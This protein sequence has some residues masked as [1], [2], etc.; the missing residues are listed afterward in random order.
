MNKIHIIYSTALKIKPLGNPLQ[1]A[2]FNKALSHIFHMCMLPTPPQPHFPSK[3]L[4]WFHLKNCL[5]HKEVKLSN[6]SQNT[7]MKEYTNQCNR[8]L[9]CFLLS[10]HINHLTTTQIYLVTLYE[11][12]PPRPATTIKCCFHTV[13]TIQ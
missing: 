1:K 6:I 10:L 11:L 7:K 3:L 4:I 2:V 12:P 9:Y 8:I 5:R 13:L